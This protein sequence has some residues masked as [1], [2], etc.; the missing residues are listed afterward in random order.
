[1]SRHDYTTPA[2]DSLTTRNPGRS[3]LSRTGM[4]VWE[5]H[6]IPPCQH[7]RFVAGTRLGRPMGQMQ[8]PLPHPSVQNLLPS[9]YCHSEALQR[10]WGLNDRK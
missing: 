3:S 9:I 2:W 10:T 5:G 4:L 1:M 7:P 6:H 8:K